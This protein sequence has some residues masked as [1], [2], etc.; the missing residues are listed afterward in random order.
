MNPEDEAWE[1]IEAKQ[2]L[3][4][5]NKAHRFA[6]IAAAEFVEDLDATDLCIMTLRKAFEIGY[7]Q[8]WKEKN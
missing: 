6:T 5:A 7:R 4:D 3:A 1:A 2:K 8:G